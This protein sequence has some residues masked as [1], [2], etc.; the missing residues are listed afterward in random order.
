MTNF[1]VQVQQDDAVIPADIDA[2]TSVTL[3]TDGRIVVN[4]SAHEWTDMHGGHVGV[5]VL[6]YQNGSPPF[7][8]W[9]SNPVRYGLDGKWVGTSQITASFTQTVDPDTMQKVDYVAIYHYNAPNDAWTDVQ[10]WVN[11][12]QQSFNAVATIAK[13]IA[14]L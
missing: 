5:V 10:A 11:G 2:N 7:W 14:S 8:L 13:S 6:L 9:T 3:Y 4:T 12:A 1:P